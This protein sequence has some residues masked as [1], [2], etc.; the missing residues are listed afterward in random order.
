VQITPKSG[1]AWVATVGEFH[2]QQIHEFGAG[3]E[4]YRHVVVENPYPALTFDLP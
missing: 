4:L 2:L 3:L 1:E